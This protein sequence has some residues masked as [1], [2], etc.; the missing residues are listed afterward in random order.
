[1]EKLTFISSKA[2]ERVVEHKYLWEQ[3]YK[4]KEGH[5]PVKLAY[6]IEVDEYKLEPSLLFWLTDVREDGDDF[7]EHQKIA[8]NARGEIVEWHRLPYQ[9]K[10]VLKKLNFKKLEN[11]SVYI[12]GEAQS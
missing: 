7:V 11:V 10:L 1:M 8:V 3:T 9:V 2:N 6:Q 12:E 5:D 4:T